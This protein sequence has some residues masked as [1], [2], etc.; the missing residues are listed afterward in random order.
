M[1]VG[2]NFNSDGFGQLSCVEDAVPTCGT[3]ATLRGKRS[4][5][6]IIPASFTASGRSHL[7]ICYVTSE[8]PVL[9]RCSS[10][11]RPLYV[12]CSFCIQIFLLKKRLLRD[13]Q[14]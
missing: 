5:D 2:S 7:L 14:L 11:I 4:I 8:T 6:E 3:A 13:I 10:L 12:F 1:Y 9:A